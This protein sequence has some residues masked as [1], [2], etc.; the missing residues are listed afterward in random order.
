MSETGLSYDMTIIRTPERR[1]IK[2]F[3]T[4]IEIVLLINVVITLINM[5]I[6]SFTEIADYD[7]NIVIE[8]Y[9]CLTINAILSLIRVLYN[10]FKCEM[11]A[12]GDR[13]CFIII[14][15]SFGFCLLIWLITISVRFY[16]SWYDYTTILQGISM[17]TYIILNAF[18]VLII[19]DAT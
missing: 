4:I 8:L 12:E 3:R 16:I 15:A 10:I 17:T 5:T 14:N 7:L 2:V 19:K 9:A 13:K 1:C 11:D 6:T 18:N